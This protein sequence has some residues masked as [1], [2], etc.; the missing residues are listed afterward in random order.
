MLAWIFL[1]GVGAYARQPQARC[2]WVLR[3]ER[4]VLF[5]FLRLAVIAGI[6]WVF[7]FGVLHDWLFEHFYSWAAGGHGG[8]HRVRPVPPSPCSSSWSWAPYE[9]IFDYAKVR[10][11]VEDRRSAIGALS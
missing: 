11:V 5:R 9:L 3:G 4:R 8:T 1:M 2:A 7:V 10:A 6:V